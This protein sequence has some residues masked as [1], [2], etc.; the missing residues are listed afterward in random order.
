MIKY[1]LI[2]LCLGGL[3]S[4]YAPKEY[5]FKEVKQFRG[6]VIHPS[7]TA[8]NERKDFVISGKNLF[9]AEIITG[10]SVTV[11]K[12]NPST[13][14]K[15]LKIYLTVKALEESEPVDKPGQRII[16]IKTLNALE[17]VTIKIMDEESEEEDR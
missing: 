17:Q 16:K 10:P 1:S 2:L 15:T 6:W 5:T 13:D 3:I 12:G 8:L 14:G 11:E 9:S 4:C 7:S